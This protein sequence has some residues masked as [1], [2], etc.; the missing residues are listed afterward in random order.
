[1]K[2]TGGKIIKLRPRYTEV[3]LG[4]GEDGEPV[5]VRLHA[6]RL[7]LVERIMRDLP[8]PEAPSK[9]VMKDKRGETV[10]DDHGKPII[11]RD[12]D[13]PAHVARMAERAKLMTVSAFVDVTEGQFEWGAKRDAFP[14]SFAYLRAILAEMEAAGIDGGMFAALDRAIAVLTQPAAAREEV[15]EAREALGAEPSPKVPEGK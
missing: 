5:T 8:A 10:R 1:M 13:D 14:D 3:R 2:L 4:I 7:G 9:G 12:A 11:I 6:P 15:N